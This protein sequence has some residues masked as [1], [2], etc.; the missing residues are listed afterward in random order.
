MTNQ[1]YYFTLLLAILAGCTLV[2]QLY[3]AML[4]VKT[5][6]TYIV[7]SAVTYANN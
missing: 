2:F 5:A 1:L 4:E 6:I 7:L 3:P